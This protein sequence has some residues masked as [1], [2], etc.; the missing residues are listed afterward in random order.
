MAKAKVMSGTTLFTKIFKKKQNAIK[1]SDQLLTMKAHR[2]LRSV[3][4]GEKVQCRRSAGI[5]V[6]FV[7]PDLWAVVHNGTPPVATLHQISLTKH[8][9]GWIKPN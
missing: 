6:S 3:N 9:V 7:A 8:L 1:R 2:D 4:V 5:V